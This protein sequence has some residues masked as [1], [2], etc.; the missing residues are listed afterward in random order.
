[1][2]KK[3]NLC[4]L[5]ICVICILGFSTVVKAD[6]S[7]YYH[8]EIINPLYENLEVKI[9]QKKTLR[10]ST[11]KTGLDI[12]EEQYTDDMVEIAKTIRDNAINRKTSFS[13]YMKTETNEQLNDNLIDLYAKELFE[14]STSEELAENSSGGDYL[15]WSW[16]EY[17]YS[18][19]W[20]SLNENN[21]FTNYITFNIE[22]IFFTT[23]EQE[24]KL[25]NDILSYIN[26]LD[27]N[28]ADYEKI[29]T[30]YNYITSN[31]K[32]D[33]E[34]LED[35]SYILKFSAFAA[36]ENN[37]AVCQGYA[38]LVYKML[39][40]YDVSGV[41]IIASESHA[42]NIVKLDKIYYCVD[43][44]WD[45]ECKSNGLDCQ[46]FLKGLKTFNNLR[47]HTM[48]AEYLVAEFVNK[49]PI[50]NEDYVVPNNENNFSENE[51]NSG[52]GIGNNENNNG[53]IEGNET[54]TSE[55]TFNG[56][57]ES[58]NN[59]SNQNQSN[60]NNINNNISTSTNTSTNPNSNN[61]TKII[62][63]NNTYSNPQ[64]ITGFR[65]K[66]NYT[67]K[68]KLK[69]NNQSQVTKYKIYLYNN[70]TKKYEC[71]KTLNGDT[72]LA[73]IKG[74]VDGTTYKFRIRAIR[75]LNGKNYYGEYTYLTVIT[76]P[77]KVTIT[78]LKA[79]AKNKLTV[80]WKKVSNSNG[81][82]IQYSTNSKFKNA[83]KIQIKN[84]KTISKVI[85]SLKRNKKYYIRIRAYKQVNG[86]KIYGD[87]SKT[88]NIKLK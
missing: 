38:S 40:E 16:Y 12:N 5:I 67:N 79:T 31:V 20:K 85:K 36:F 68:I 28:T 35:D 56:E 76:K 42:W 2:N 72:L 82:I 45:A 10:A 22:F 30:I 21:K 11:K 24:K 33:N 9:N 57:T 58:G 50:S 44:T 66:D 81:Y 4:I 26:G 1:M 83:K 48:E 37:S 52:D 6:N 51:N 55:N 8:N 75:T 19:N 29:K 60:I 65:V 18:A 63:T 53:K 73:T 64:K 61:N 46:F 86:K 3:K 80:N 88:K 77:N 69:W 54:S 34:H 17:S 47:E 87:Y 49:Y 43:S 59:N 70:K 39:K 14:I 78:K 41:R 62:I 7:G 84:K 74:L 13:I 32:Y 15:K 71:K 27:S 25:D 23:Y